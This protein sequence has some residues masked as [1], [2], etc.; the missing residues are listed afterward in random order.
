MGNRNGPTDIGNKL[1]VTKGKREG[2]EGQMGA[3]DSQIQTINAI[4]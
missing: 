1:M 4:Y 2:G 3:W